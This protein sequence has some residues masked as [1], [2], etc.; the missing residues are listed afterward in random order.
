MQ[1]TVAERTLRLRTPFA[2]SYG[3]VNERT[4]LT[5]TLA[6]ADGLCGYGEAAPLEPYDGVSLA[7][8]HAALEAYRPVLMQSAAATGAQLIEA[9]RRVADLPQA[10]AAIDLALWDRAGR[11]AGRPVA[12]LLTDAPASEVTVNATVAATDRAAAAEQAARAA[13]AG[14]ECVKVKVGVGDDAGRLA[15]V[16]AAVGPHVA[17]RVDANGAWDVEQ[18]VSAIEALHPVG[19]E[20]VEEP[21]H[22]LR[23]VREVRERVAARVAIDETAAE[24]GALGAGVA[25]AVCLKI[26]RCGGIAGLLA[27]AA[28]V[29][30][31]G[32]EVYLASTLDGPLGIA[33]AVHAAAAL[34]SRGPLPPCG[35]ATLGLFEDLDDPL[36]V[37]TG[38]IAVPSAPGLG[39]EPLQSDSA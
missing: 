35:L 3:T 9:C 20:L 19:L 8:V 36:T 26:S 7:R 15:A 14:Y 4:L 12:A 24:H 34:A 28:L 5:V 16:R 37:R 13:A 23:A 30:A 10:L 33:A 6:D 31:S 25:D 11:R 27:A 22:G 39:V 18:A 38:R 32:A 17:L 1:L 2:T 21:T 29:R